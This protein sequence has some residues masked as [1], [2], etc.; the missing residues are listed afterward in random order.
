[1]KDIVHV[2]ESR[3]CCA[4]NSEKE[5]ALSR[6]ICCKCKYSIPGSNYEQLI[7]DVVHYR[8]LLIEISNMIIAGRSRKELVRVIESGLRKE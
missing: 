2:P 1:M 4:P 5:N 8:S 6:R 7:A 3:G